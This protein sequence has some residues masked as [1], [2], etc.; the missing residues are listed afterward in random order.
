MTIEKK[1]TNNTPIQKP[2]HPRN[3]LT[4]TP[5]WKP[6]CLAIF[7]LDIL[8]GNMICSVAGQNKGSSAL[9]KNL[10]KRICEADYASGSKRAGK[11]EGRMH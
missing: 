5:I 11:F 6:Q 2:R 9:V 8:T 7:V 3:T 4:T 10:V 1:Q